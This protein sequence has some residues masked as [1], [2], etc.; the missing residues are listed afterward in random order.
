MIPGPH[1]P[2]ATDVKVFMLASV[3]LITII[4][5]VVGLVY[6]RKMNRNK[7]QGHNNKPTELSGFFNR[8]QCIR[9][10]GL[11][12]LSLLLVGILIMLLKP[13]NFQGWL[14]TTYAALLITLQAPLCFTAAL[15]MRTAKLNGFAFYVLYGI[16]FAMLPLGLLL[17][18]PLNFFAFISPYYWIAWAWMIRPPLQGL[19]CGIIGILLSLA[20]VLVIYFYTSHKTITNQP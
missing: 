1:T 15:R 19:L 6:G 17:H 4:P 20:Y 13:I 9:Y 18:H 3:S 16:L 12:L 11:F 14:R 8:Q 10:S 2:G 5:L 7:Q